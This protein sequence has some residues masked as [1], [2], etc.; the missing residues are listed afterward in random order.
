LGTASAPPASV[1]VD[2]VTT[3]ATTWAMAQFMD[4]TGANIG[5][6]AS[7]AVGLANAA[8]AITSHNIVDITTGLAPTTFPQG[9]TSPTRKLYTLADI[10]ASCVESSGGSQCANLFSAATLPGGIAP[11]TTLQAA[12]DIAR[13]PS[14]NVTGLYGLVLI[15]AP[16]QPALS[17]VPNDWTLAQSFTGGGLSGPTA[18][19]I[20]ASG[21]IW[22]ADYNSAVSELSPVGAALS[23]STGF[24]GGG[25][26]ESL[27][28]AIDQMGRVWVTDE[29]SP[30]GVNSGEGAMTIL[31]SDG[32]I[33]SGASGISGGGLDFPQ[34][35][36]IDA[37]G[38]AWVAN[39]ANASVTE[40]GSNLSPM[41]PSSGFTGG[42]LGFPS[43][44]A[45]DASGNLWISDQSSDAISELGQKG[46]ALSPPSGYTGGGLDGPFGI[47]IDQ[48]GNV[49]VGNYFGSDLAGLD[50][51]SSM[52]PGTPFSPMAGYTGGG[53]ES[54]AGL[55]IDGGGNI[56]A[57]NYHGT[58]ISEFA[59]ANSALPGAAI[60]GNSGYTD[61]SLVSPYGIAIDPSGNVW[62]AD[63]D[64]GDGRAVTELLGAATP[65]KAPLIGPAQ[66]P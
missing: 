61:S 62:I 33:L 27:G 20:D 22:I 56:W 19:A 31:G 7:N 24:T 44:L 63:N 42:G 32:T 37:S 26:F 57:T 23:P 1:N 10:L 53:L 65:V 51:S 36:A 34:A 8:S 50:G 15:N 16:Y 29:Q 40:F 11:T 30:S 46:G 21:D 66:L 39:Y 43:A 49:W 13:N 38:S 3:V 6:P 9:V 59:G 47:A 35:V 45:F 54:P 2:E 17:S 48:L 12:I 4:S 28:L 18:L 41:S 5:A 52:T 64:A 25:L 55:A 58:S 60:S 14:N